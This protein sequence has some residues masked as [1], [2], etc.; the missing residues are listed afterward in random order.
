MALTPEKA[1]K[2]VAL[3]RKAYGVPEPFIASDP[4]DQ[5]IAT[6]LSQNT[7]DRNSL[8][9]FRVLK[10]RFASWGAV[11]QS[12]VR[13]VASPIRSAGLA[14]IKARRIKDVLREIRRREGSLDLSRLGAMP[15]RD[16]FEYL[17]SLK[18]VGPKT[19]SCVL[20][21]SFGKGIMPVDTHIFRVAKRM[22]FIGDEVTIEEAHR[23]LTGTVPRRLIYDFHLGIIEHG[24]RTCRA[25]GPKCGRCVLYGMCAYPRKATLRK[26]GTRT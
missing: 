10:K 5:L 23:M 19:A 3:L 7:T 4:V 14:N 21:F 6:V 8:A 20:L 22:G 17:T 16:S 15:V 26:K 2:I 9:A 12:P 11:M 13:S 24:R 18:G 1:K 25:A